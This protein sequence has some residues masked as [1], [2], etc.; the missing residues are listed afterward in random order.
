MET[1]TVQWLHRFV[2]QCAHGQLHPMGSDGAG[3]RCS[4]EQHSWK[5]TTRGRT[6]LLGKCWIC[7][8]LIKQLTTPLTNGGCSGS[9]AFNCIM[10]A[11]SVRGGC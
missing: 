11:Y 4:S 5:Y 6:A 3:Q 1:M 2:W 9:N 8:S 10:L 7:N